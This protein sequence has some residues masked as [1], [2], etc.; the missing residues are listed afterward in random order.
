MADAR[1]AALDSE[2]DDID[3]VI[4][5]IENQQTEIVADLAA[6]EQLD[7][8]LQAKVDAGTATV[9]VTAELV[10][11]RAERTRLENLQQTLQGQLLARNSPNADGTTGSVAVA[12]GQTIPIEPPAGSSPPGISTTST[13]I[14]GVDPVVPVTDPMPPT[15][16][17]VDPTVPV[18]V[19]P[20]PDDTKTPPVDATPA[21]P[22]DPPT[23]PV[24]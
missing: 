2:L 22:A 15:S 9:D 17:P 23:P 13:P 21:T 4:S 18:A 14:T 7:K 16:M 5:E 3:T 24:A 6:C 12:P 19:S 11:L 10:R 1:F 20:L 8:D